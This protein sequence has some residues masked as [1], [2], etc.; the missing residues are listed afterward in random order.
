[1]KGAPY[2]NNDGNRKKTAPIRTQPAQKESQ[3]NPYKV[4]FLKKEV[5]LFLVKD[6]DA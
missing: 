3:L 4:N 2:D 6:D 5:N 1:M